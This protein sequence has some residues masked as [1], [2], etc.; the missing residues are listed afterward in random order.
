MTDV[1]KLPIKIIS[2]NKFTCGGKPFGIPIIMD[3]NYNLIEPINRWIISLAKGGKAP[4]SIQSYAESIFDLL[5]TIQASIDCWGIC[6]WEDIEEEHLRAYH[7]FQCNKNSL[8]TANQY[9]DRIA[10]F[11]RWAFQKGYIAVLPWE[12]SIVA[13]PLSMIERNY[14]SSNK[15]S[16]IRKSIKKPVIKS[17]VRVYSETEIHA[18]FEHLSSRDRLIAM[19][20]LFAGLRREEIAR[21]PY[22]AIPDSDNIEEDDIIV[23]QLTHTK[24][25]KTQEIVVP[26]QLID[27]TNRYIK[28]ERQLFVNEAIKKAKFTNQMYTPPFEVFVTQYGFPLTPERI[29]KLWRQA[30]IKAGVCDGVFHDCRHTF[31]DNLYDDL[32][33][34]VRLNPHLTI[35]VEKSV[36]QALR[37]QS[38]N[39][40][41]R[42]YISKK[43]KDKKLIAR[44][45]KKR[46]DELKQ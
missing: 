24:A 40:T 32:S 42:F 10:F 43:Q 2:T 6:S 17:D 20:A 5:C 12:G 9:I 21:L 27:E 33:Q 4:R 39:T 14:I 34:E 41:M 26:L 16:T 37:H 8:E 18:I 23:I 31:A 44:A 45:I 1:I 3:S 30:R 28:F 19:W 46:Y 13:H 15:S 25:R 29:S 11:Y 38:F 22:A 36:M 7:L 35:N